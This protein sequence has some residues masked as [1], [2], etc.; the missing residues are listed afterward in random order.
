MPGQYQY[1]P[2]QQQ[3]V[4]P[5]APMS[6]QPA[7]FRRIQQS[8]AVEVPYNAGS[9]RCY[10]V[11][12]GTVGLIKKFGKF[13]RSVDPGLYQLNPFCEK[14]QLIDVRQRV[15]D[16]PRQTILTK[17]NVSIDIDSVLYWDILDPYIAAYLVIDVQKAL[18]DRTLTTLRMVLGNRTLQDTVEHRETIAQ[19]IRDVI[20]SVAESW[21]VKV[22]SILIKDVILGPELLQSMSAAASQRRIGDSKIIAAQAEVNAAKLMRQASDILN[23]PAAMQIRFLETLQT[24]SKTPGT[25]IIFMPP[26]DSAVTVKGAMIYDHLK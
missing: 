18:I 10:E 11:P 22:E 1:P 8:Y 2:P 7:P 20:D 19:E 25:K 3:Q 15:Q 12:Q 4:Y 9:D 6:T 26:N 24:M 5:M 13:I 17:D 21:G 23:S 16:C 14:M